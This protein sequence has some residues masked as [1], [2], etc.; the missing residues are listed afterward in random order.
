MTGGPTR[1]TVLAL[2]ST[3]LVGAAACTSDPN[4]VSEQAR[5][6]DQ[7]GYV[8]GDGSVE[9]VPR[10]ERGEPV[11]LSGK[12]LGGGEFRSAEARGEILLLNVWASWCGPCVAEMPVLQQVWEE[13][14]KAGAPV[15]FVGINFRDN[16]AGGAAFAKRAGVTF[17]NI[18]DESGTT[19]L[20]LQGKAPTVP[21]TLVLDREGRIAARVNGP[22]TAGTLRG[23]LEDAV[24]GT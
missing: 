19:I 15:R 11:E 13:Q 22:V 14:Q 6:G 7:K 18:G 3:A 23:L 21:T 17:P 16:A 4:S 9:T 10:A 8:S 1:R 20:A 24:A 12:L 5:R 2:A